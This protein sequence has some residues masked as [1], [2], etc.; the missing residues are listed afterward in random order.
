MSLPKHEKSVSRMLLS[1][2]ALFL[3]LF[4]SA[5]GLHLLRPYA[6]PS[7]HSEERANLTFRTETLGASYWYAQRTLRLTVY[8]MENAAE[9]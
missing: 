7:I 2:P 9:R 5:C 4:L 8:E 6:A 3:V 1:F